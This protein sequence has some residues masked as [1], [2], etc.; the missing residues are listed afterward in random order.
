M[1]FFSRLGFPDM[2]SKCLIRKYRTQAMIHYAKL[3]WPRTFYHDA[4]SWP[5]LDNADPRHGWAAEDVANAPYGP[6]SADI[7]GKL[8]FYLRRTLSSFMTRL[9]DLEKASFKLFQV[10]AASLPDHLELASFARIEVSNISDYGWL[11][12]HRTLFHMIPLLQNKVDN[13]HATLITL[14]LNAVEETEN[15]NTKPDSASTRKLLQYIPLTSVWPSRYDPTLVK[16]DMARDLVTDHDTV[17]DRYV[18]LC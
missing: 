14:F 3:T 15:Q 2:T 5:M 12:I 13:P 11:G 1:D 10:D 9:R 4:S 7:Y 17:F 16:F 6:A 8:Y 18:L